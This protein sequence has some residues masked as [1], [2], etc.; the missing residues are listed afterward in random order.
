MKPGL[1]KS[2]DIRPENGAGLFLQPSW[3]CR[4]LSCEHKHENVILLYRLFQLLS[5]VLS[6]EITPN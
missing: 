6:P 2:Y 4:H 5:V 3:G 1:V